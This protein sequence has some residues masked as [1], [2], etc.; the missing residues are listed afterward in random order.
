[1]EIMDKRTQ[2]I[3]DKCHK[4]IEKG[5]GLE[6]CLERFKGFEKDIREYFS[7]AE[8]LKKLKQAAPSKKFTKNSLDSIIAIA[9]AREVSEADPT[10]RIPPRRLLL[11]PAMIFII[12]IVI[13]V[14]SFSGTL[15][16]SQESM[17][18]ETL[19]PLKRSF[20]S[21]QLAIYPEGMKG[22]LHLKFLGNR[23][24][25][26]E[27][28]LD[29]GDE[30]DPL[31]IEELISDMD[32]QHRAC[33]QYNCIDPVNEDDIQDSINSIRNRYHKRFGKD[34][35]TGQEGTN[36]HGNNEA[37]SNGDSTGHNQSKGDQGNGK[38]SS[39]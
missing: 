31:L 32:R 18:G 34:S 7:I 35:S 8:D 29:A 2:S 3:I 23:I 14:F 17:P 4:L 24:S 33:N 21:F 11:R 26:A 19:Y 13:S 10:V 37:D 30:A 1:V 6:Y 5:Y 15:F 28:L 12:F 39:K 38:G 9:K 25:E 16:A 27:I 22:D 36:K 20:E